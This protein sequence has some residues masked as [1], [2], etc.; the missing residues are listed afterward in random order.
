ME[1][2]ARHRGRL[3]VVRAE[4][5]LVRTL[6]AESP[7][8]HPTFAQHASDTVPRVALLEL[9]GGRVLGSASAVITADGYLVDELS[10]YFGTSRARQHP[11][12]W[13]PFPPPPLKVPGSLGVLASRGDRNYYHFLADVLPRLAIVEQC[14]EVAAPDV[15][16]VPVATRFQQELLDLAGITAERRIDSAKVPHVTADSLVVPGL[17]SVTVRNPPWVQSY[18]RELLMT[19]PIE[20]VPGRGIY[21][22]RGTAR[23]NRVVLNEP[24]VTSALAERGFAVIDPGQMSVREQIAA[25]AEA[26]V[27]V[28]PHGAALANLAFASPGASVIELFP[29]AYAK[30]DYWWLANGVEGLRYHYLLGTGRAVRSLGRFIVADIEIEVPVLTGMVDRILKGS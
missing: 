3:H 6:P 27:I 11:L 24:D 14:R 26:S 25:F 8:P 4:E 1:Q 9:D 21:V 18:L 19:E 7:T 2:A 30:P 22:T 10:Q 17:P 5:S 28:A 13:Q 20:R 23:N 15:W 16:Y 12:Y 29:A